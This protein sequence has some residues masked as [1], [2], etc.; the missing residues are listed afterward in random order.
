MQQEPISLAC[1]ETID[2]DLRIV[3]TMIR[4]VVDLLIL[5]L[6]KMKFHHPRGDRGYV[7]DHGCDRDREYDDCD[8][9]PYA[10]K[11][12]VV[13]TTFFYLLVLVWH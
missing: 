7:H 10:C 2:Q 3:P 4:V 6:K 13:S 12:F 5:L 9:G 1:A 11:V 8:C